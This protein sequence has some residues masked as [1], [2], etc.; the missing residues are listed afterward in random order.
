FS[1]S[2]SLLSVLDRFFKR[3]ARDAETSRRDIEPLRLETRH[4]VLESEAFDAANEIG[5]RDRKVIEVQIDR[6]DGLVTHLVDIATNR[7]T[8]RSLFDHKSAHA[9]M[10]RL[11]G[12]I[13]LRE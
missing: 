11:S 7:Q 4:H 13:G 6:F 8:G 10:R 12:G 1:K 9:A 5:R 3:R 2:V